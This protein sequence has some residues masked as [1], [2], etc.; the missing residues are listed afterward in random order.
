[1]IPHAYDPHADRGV[2]AW[3]RGAWFVAA[4]VA[5]PASDLLQHRGTAGLVGLSLYVLLVLV[6]AL[7][8]VQ[9]AVIRIGP[10]SLSYRIGHEELIVETATRPIRVPFERIRSVTVFDGA[11][12]RYRSGLS[13]ANYHVGTFFAPAGVVRVAASRVDGQ[14]LLIEH[15][16]VF[17][18][19][20]RP[21]RLFIS[22]D[23]PKATRLV[24][25]DLLA[26]RLER[27]YR[28]QP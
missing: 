15:W 22:P 4:A 12:L 26:A 24:V 11:G 18:L 23:H 13:L 2:R 28:G 6:L 9:L 3:L 5:L 19:G 20:R 1:M 8:A 10:S 27:L 14:G 7:L 17:G 25:A 21:E 16:G